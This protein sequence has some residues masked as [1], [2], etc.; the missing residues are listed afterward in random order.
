MFKE[1]HIAFVHRFIQKEFFFIK[2]DQRAGV[3]THY[4]WQ[5]EVGC[6]GQQITGKNKGFAFVTDKWNGLPVGMAIEK[7]NLN[8]R[9]KFAGV[10][11]EFQAA[12]FF[13]GFYVFYEK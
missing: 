8:A 7:A 4:P 11:K 9:E 1:Q 3:V 6:G 12:A 2:C 13:N 10:V 5:G